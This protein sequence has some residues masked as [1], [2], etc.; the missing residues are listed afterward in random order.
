[1][2]ARLLGVNPQTLRVLERYG[3]VCPSRTEN[4][5]RLYSENDLVLLQRICHLIR[6]ERINMAGVRVILRMEGRL[7]G[8]DLPGDEAAEDDAGE[9]GRTGR[10][11]RPGFRRIPV[12]V[13]E[14]GDAREDGRGAASG[15]KEV[16]VYGEGRGHR[17]GDH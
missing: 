13:P 2:A 1:M 11:G 7:S 8:P 10:P 15:D 3:L 12:E 5:I 9:H 6:V 17:S 16:R 14:E 4:N